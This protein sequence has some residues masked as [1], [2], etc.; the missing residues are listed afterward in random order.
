[1]ATYIHELK[2]WPHFQWAAAQVAGKLAAVRNRQGRLTGRMEEL[3]LKLQSEANL[4]ALTEEVTK[5]SEIEGE[6]L[7]R[8]QVR[9][10]EMLASEYS[11]LIY[12]G[13]WYSALHGDILA[14]M[15]SSQQYVSGDARLKLFRGV[16]S[17]VGRRSPNS[18]YQHALA[19]YEQGD[20]FDHNSALGFIALWGLP[21]KTQ[22][23]AQLLKDGKGENLLHFENPLLL[24]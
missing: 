19:T 8:E 2:D 15:R 11:R 20:T 6:I 12:N 14:F 18:L 24:G 22:A 4:E 17:V 10:K 1:M 9:V 3:G 13:L 7:S 23:Q 5:S 16:C 21:V